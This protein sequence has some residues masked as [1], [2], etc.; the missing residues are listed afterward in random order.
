MNG[1]APSPSTWKI[2]DVCEEQF[3]QEERQRLGVPPINPISY[4]YED[5]TQ[6]I[7]MRWIAKLFSKNGIT[8]TNARPKFLVSLPNVNEADI[9]GCYTELSKL[10]AMP[11][12][13]IADVGMLCS[14]KSFPQ[15]DITAP[16]ARL[17]H[18]VAL[19]EMRE[20][21]ILNRYNELSGL[22][23]MLSGD[24]VNND[25]SMTARN[26]AV[27]AYNKVREPKASREHN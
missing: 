12:T 23:T 10:A 2:E 20:E 1:T 11:S 13:Y 16:N 9:I 22:S 24:F 21:V 8:A 19:P 15:G 3:L 14:S 4:K 5:Y 27:D 7:G 18:M 17:K 6:D 25:Y 26:E